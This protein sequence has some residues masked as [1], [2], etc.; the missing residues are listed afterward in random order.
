MTSTLSSASRSTSAEAVYRATAELILKFG[1]RRLRTASI[2]ARAGITES[3]LFRSHGN[4]LE[5]LSA[6]DRWAWSEVTQQVAASSFET[7]PR[8]AREAL[9][10]DAAAIWQMRENQDE[11]LPAIFAFLFLR[12]KHELEL[13]RS[14]EELAF[15]RRVSSHCARIIEE[16][17]QGAEAQVGAEGFATLVLNYFATVWLSWE[18]MPVEADNPLDPHSLTGDEAQLGLSI[19]IDQVAGMDE[20]RLSLVE[21]DR[22]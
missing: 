6:T 12:R 10:T 4:L 22:A 8:T 16:A 5:V 15:A 13:S 9:L 21:A 17:D 3:T 7:S 20:R 1:T 2:A 14:P 19:L 18:T 11:G